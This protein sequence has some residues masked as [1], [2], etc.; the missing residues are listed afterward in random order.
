MSPDLVKARSNLGQTRSN[1]G[2]TSVNC[3]QPQVNENA[4]AAWSFIVDRRIE[5][6]EKFTAIQTYRATV[7]LLSAQVAFVQEMSHG[8]WFVPTANC[9][10]C[11]SRA[12]GLMGL[13]FFFHVACTACWLTDSVCTLAIFRKQRSYGLLTCSWL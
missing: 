12:A 2:Q 13:I 11:P 7:S 5:A 4:E 10:D 6:P 1:I 8:A 9:V 3:G